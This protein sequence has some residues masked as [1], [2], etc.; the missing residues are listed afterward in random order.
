[1]TDEERKVLERRIVLKKQF[2][3][4]TMQEMEAKFALFSMEAK[5]ALFSDA[6]L[7]IKEMEGELIRESVP[8]TR[9]DAP[10]QGAK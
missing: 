2:V 7:E 8:E 3:E 1:M 6:M 4:V 10:Q 9:E 5:F